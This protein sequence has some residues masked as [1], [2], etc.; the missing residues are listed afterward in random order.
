M[1][2]VWKNA[3]EHHQSGRLDQA[4]A[5]Y[6]IV[7]A[8]FPDHLQSLNNLGTLLV[9]QRRYSD[10]LPCYQ[11]ARE[12]EPGDAGGLYRL[13]VVLESL[14]R[15]EEALMEM[16]RAVQ[17]QPEF[18][19]GWRGGGKV[20][21]KLGR[22][23]SALENFQRALSLNPDD[24]DAL[25]NIGVA[26]QRLGQIDLATS[27]FRQ[28]IAV[29]PKFADAHYNLGNIQNE[30]VT[31]DGLR[32]HESAQASYALALESDP[33][34]EFLYGTWLHSKLKLCEWSDAEVQIAELERRV[35]RSERATP[36]FP[37]LA[38]TNSSALQKR[39]AEIWARSKVETGQQL[40][41]ITKYSKHK[42][43]RI[44]Y[45]SADFHNHPGSF[46]MAGMFE[47]HDRSK[48]ELIAFSFGPVTG[49]QM[50][51]RVSEAF[52][53]F[54][55]VRAMSDR[56]IALL[57]R[58]MEIDI[59]IDRKGYTKH[60]RPTIFSYRAAPV[61]VSYLAYPGTMGA[62]FIDYL[63]A[64]PIV[65]PEADRNHY[66]EKIAY[67][68]NCYQVND[69]KREIADK[70][71]SRAEL[72]LPETG[73]VFCCFNNNYKIL[74]KTF[75]SW[76]RILRHVDSSVLWLFE[77]N[78]TVA[79]NL[80]NEA[81][82]R[83]VSG[84]RLVFA[85]RMKLSEHL[86]RHRAA[87]LF[88]DTLPYN[89]H[90]TASDALW[91]G[92]PVLTLQGE[93]F[94]GRVAASLLSAIELPEMI[95]RTPEEFEA[96]AV[97][98]ATNPDR[99]SMIRQKLMANR[100]T[101]P[102]F[103]CQ[104]F[105]R[106]IEALFE[107]MYERY[108]RDLRPD[109]LAVDRVQRTLSRHP[110]L[111]ASHQHQLVFDT[112][113]RSNPSSA[114]RHIPHV[115]R[116]GKA[117]PVNLSV[118]T[119]LKSGFAFHAQGN[120]DQAQNV[121]NEVAELQPSNHIAI[122]RLATI[123]AQRGEF[124]KALP[125]YAQALQLKPDFP[126]ALINQ[127]NAL[128]SIKRLDDA[129]ESY[130]AALKLDSNN[131]M[132][133]LNL[134]YTLVELRRFE[135]ALE[136]FDHLLQLKPENAVVHGSR[137]GVLLRLQRY[138]DALK[139]YDRAL[140][141]KPDQLVYLTNRGTVL[142][143]LNRH[144]EALAC[145]ERVLTIKPD[146]PEA[147]I[148]RGDALRDLRRRDEALATYDQLLAI[149]PDF[150]EAHINRGVVLDGLKRPGEAQ[151]SYARA[152]DLN[153]DF[154]LLYGMWVHA[155]MRLCDWTE[156]D[157]R[158][159]AV[160]RRVEQGENVTAPFP[161]LAISNSPSL[162]RK[163]AEI[164]VK[165]KYGNGSTLPPIARYPRHDKIR[166]GYF[167]ADFHNHPGSYLM[168]GLFEA[169]DREQ[170]EIIAFSFGPLTGD[171]M[172]K[173][174]SAAFDSFIDVRAMSDKEVALLA[175]RMEID[176]AIDRKG[177]TQ[178]S[179]PGI[180][181]LRAAPIQASYLAYPGTLGG[182]FIDYLI[183]DPI[184][185]PE[186][187]REHYSE[188]IAYLPNCYQVNDVKREIADKHY[189]RAE[190]G[191][192]ETGFVFCCFN[193]N[194]K[195]TPNT[196]DSW[197][198]ILGHVEGSV[199]WLLEDNLTAATN[200]RSEAE[201]RNIC[202]SRLIF[203]SRMRLPEHLARHCAAD[204]LLDTLPYNA[205]T[206]ASDALWAGLPVLTLLGQTFAGRVAASL[207]SAINMPEL[208]TS[209]AEEFEALA[210]ELATNPVKLA[211]IKQKLAA[212]RLTTPLFDCKGFTRDL[213]ALF[214]TMVE[215]YRENLPP[216]CIGTRSLN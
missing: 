124:Y 137:G 53:R 49:D 176:I 193:N 98:L 125:L 192:P 131:E 102:L 37:F 46:L 108:Q 140:A 188:K 69:N 13:G 86:A 196:F 52:D 96:L 63:I 213:E 3:L 44:A 87:D 119:K 189:S 111:A 50:Q 19:A 186:A 216:D 207:L 210:I 18:A 58:D 151:A 11:R 40:P 113:D 114:M 127:G 95:T 170:F 197:M 54:I 4:E 17:I 41:V 156:A 110:S 47:M 93:T 174:V 14:G 73:F 78:A 204:L 67:L 172:Q 16:T 112:G 104:R 61:Q 144:D 165:A 109:H 154:D 107:A 76:M 20:L 147:L 208:I 160:T 123:A 135:S 166:I 26:Y 68:P 31:L 10:A 70:H 34:F 38:V 90:T 185:I 64:D 84:S 177:Y 122:E 91:A 161:F 25:N 155:N 157:A 215:R 195:I 74:P 205:H 212:N 120:L 118:E 43:I 35:E 103:D 141:V 162:Q 83:G 200:L 171:Q 22:L 138:E 101:T 201:R 80:R 158:I 198:K 169:H 133:L 150:I 51:K 6:R 145:Y 55:D 116:R 59:A 85:N 128:R 57:A 184:V 130:Q 45:F 15:L 5:G 206:T 60:S 214:T 175:R 2:S 94:A 173:R 39:S 82:R 117:K 142:R 32:L 27:K 191:L 12:L 24:A 180:F 134:G 167:S 28:A 65:I 97:E 153:P 66:S 136:V 148:N 89:A 203:A 72:G 152:C 182:D 56:E 75:H 71:Y 88:L 23:Q 179:R 7:L 202:A 77:T 42:R 190:L 209:T 187:D 132:S 62:D 194:Y 139:S 30:V 105:T 92:L 126:D 143:G 48:F 9:A 1:M 159:E 168:A 164:L 33:N 115:S 163:C 36:P 99:L 81:E 183:A 106:D 100:L 29:R 211:G 79:M 181:A 199:L 8:Q 121:F 129:V 178:D 146:Y 149:K 21:L